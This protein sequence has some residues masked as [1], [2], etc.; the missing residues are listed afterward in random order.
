[1]THRDDA[2]PR[3]LDPLEVQDDPQFGAQDPRA[4]VLLG[5]GRHLDRDRFHPIGGVLLRGG[6]DRGR[7][8][9]VQGRHLKDA[10]D[11]DRGRCRAMA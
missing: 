8:N 10:S 6:V 5:Q 11:R 7:E 3:Y 4:R 1:M 2:A 9:H